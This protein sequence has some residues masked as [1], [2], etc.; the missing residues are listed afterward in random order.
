M[1]AKLSPAMI[2]ALEVTGLDDIMAGGPTRAA[3]M[4]RGLVFK[5]DGHSRFGYLTGAGRE[6]A[7]ELQAR[8]CAARKDEPK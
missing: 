1:S 6:L 7:A 3:L 8:K 4:R 2:R 5:R